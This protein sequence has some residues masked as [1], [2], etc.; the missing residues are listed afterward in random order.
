M[1]FG[2]AKTQYVPPP[3]PSPPPANAP[4]TADA[5]VQAAGAAG[6]SSGGYGSRASGLAGTIMTSP[7]GLT[8]PAATTKKTLLGQ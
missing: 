5:S 1:S 2:K 3:D 7:Q 8:E 4:T 6:R